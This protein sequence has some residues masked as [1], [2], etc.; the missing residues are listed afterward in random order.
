MRFKSEVNPLESSILKGML[1]FALPISVS[2]LLTML[3]SCAD[4]IVIGRFGHENAISAIGVSAAV[5][6]F[7]VGGFTALAVGVT[8]VF[9]KYFGENQREKVSEL[10][11]SLPVTALVLGAALSFAAI[12]CSKR[13]LHLLN[14][15][16]DILPDALLYFRIYFLGVPLTMLTGFLSSALQAKGNSYTPFFFQ[17]A[18]SCIN[19]ALN[20]FFVIVLDWNVA[21][22]AAATVI[23]Q[24][25][26]AAAM[27]FYL[28]KQE[29]ELKLNLRKL[30]VF[31]GMKQVFAVGIPASLESIIL[32]L[33][34]VIIASV[35][36]RFDNTV[37]AGNTVATSIEGLMVITF[38]GFASAST[39]FISQNYGAGKMDR[40]RTVYR[41]TLITVFAAA[42]LAGI[43]LFAF[44]SKLV[45]LFTTDSAI[46][47]NAQV[48]M[49][50][51]CLFFGLCGTMNVISG[52]ERGLGDA[53]TPLFISIL[54]SVVFRLTWIF[55]YA[56]WKGTVESIYLSYPICWGICTFLNHLAFRRL[57]RRQQCSVHGK[58]LQK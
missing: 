13:I 33:S 1:M 51:M 31:R 57:F 4:T 17:A 38:T 49:F 47:E 21:G 39:V 12:V 23:S 32:N 43:L 41:T 37:I 30:T 7:L 3:F 29:N 26:L 25:L 19:I 34:G 5:L 28:G 6:N 55:T 15:P 36:N 16:D 48:R 8:V 53:K 11:H 10:L 27:T 52:C 35:I 9:G 56:A 14:C 46:V 20:L 45:W 40:V 44:S 18:A 54:C 50:Y 2:S 58:E 22:V 24:F 42:E